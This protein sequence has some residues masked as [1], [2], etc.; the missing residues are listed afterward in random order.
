MLGDELEVV[1]GR[2]LD[3]LRHRS[4]D[5]RA[6]LLSRTIRLSFHESNARERHGTLFPRRKGPL[7][8]LLIASV[9]RKPLNDFLGVLVRRK[10]RIK[11]LLDQP[12][13]DDQSQPLDQRHRFHFE[14]GQTQCARKIQMLV[15]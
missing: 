7:Q 14:G 9:L 3:G 5:N 4:I 12:V 11:D 13:R 8:W 2:N 15:A 6:D 1:L 10:Y